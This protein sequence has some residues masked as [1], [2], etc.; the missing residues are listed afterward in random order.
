MCPLTSALNCTVEVC[1]VGLAPVK[2]A[3]SKDRLSPE[4]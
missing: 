4:S 1:N 2:L 3:V